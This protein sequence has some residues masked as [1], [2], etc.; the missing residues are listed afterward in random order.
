MNI[1]RARK[2]MRNAF[3]KDPDFAE[4]Y[5]ANIAM[6]LHDKYGITDSIERN[7][8]GEDILELIFWD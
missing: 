4:T 3:E 2:V 5:V 1:K 8:A 6:L 7:R